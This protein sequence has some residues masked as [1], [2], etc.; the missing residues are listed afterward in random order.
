MLLKS[1]I[2]ALVIP[3]SNDHSNSAHLLQLYCN[4]YVLTHLVSF[5]GLY[6]SVR[7]LCVLEENGFLTCN[8]GAWHCSGIVPFMLL[9]LVLDF[10]LHT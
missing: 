2:K 1:R 7:S 10:S 6:F 5:L 3:F 9:L 8:E 4:L